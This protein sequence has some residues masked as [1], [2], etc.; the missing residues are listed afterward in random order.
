MTWLI[1]S[2]RPLTLNELAAAVVIDPNTGFSNEHRLDNDERVL[3]ICGSFLKANTKTSIVELA[4]FSVHEF[5]TSDVL[6]S[7][8]INEFHVSSKK[9]HAFVLAS[10]ITFLSSEHFSQ[11]RALD[12][13]TLRDRFRDPLFPYAAY[14]WP[15]HGY[16]LDEDAAEWS[17]VIKFFHTD[18]LAAWGQLWD[19]LE[20]N[21]NYTISGVSCPGW[22]D[23]PRRMRAGCPDP[24]ISK[25][26]LDRD[27][28]IA[29]CSITELRRPLHLLYY[30][31][32]LSFMPIFDWITNHDRV[33]EGVTLD[34]SHVL[35]KVLPCSVSITPL[36]AAVRNGNIAVVQRLI[37]MG[38][39]VDS[40]NADYQGCSYMPLAVAA[41]QRN[42]TIARLLVRA[43]ANVIAKIADGGMP[44]NHAF[45]D[46]N[47]IIGYELPTAELIDLLADA[48]SVNNAGRFGY[49]LYIAVSE[50]IIKTAEQLRELGADIDTCAARYCRFCHRQ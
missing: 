46:E 26:S 38:A 22:R 42:M 19:I 5:I 44:L 41:G 12:R 21:A 31:S 11:G 36:L 50:G 28:R 35:H 43:C 39:D 34:G 29:L 23:P 25:L 2:K 17:R 45:C 8:E 18:H 48:Q 24:E 9:G 47:Q 32:T 3:Q 15:A 49:P 10:Y 30:A 13:H 37:A 40:R 16:Q 4:H 14:Y 1:Y 33:N 7:G 20:L 6:P 27:G